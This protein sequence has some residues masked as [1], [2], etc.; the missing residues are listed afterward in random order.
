M[1]KR[2][3]YNLLHLLNKGGPA[4]IPSPASDSDASYWTET[5]SYGL[6][7]NALVAAYPNASAGAQVLSNAGTANQNI[8]KTNVL[9]GYGVVQNTASS[10]FA[11]TTEAPT[12]G[13]ICLLKKGISGTDTNDTFNFTAVATR[14]R[15]ASPGYDYY[16]NSAV[17]I[18]AVGGTTLLSWDTIIMRWTGQAVVIRINGVQKASF[19]AHGN[20]NTNNAFRLLPSLVGQFAALGRWTTD[21]G[22][23]RAATVESYLRT[24]YAHY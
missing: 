4:V 18:V 1:L 15:N 7:N 5:H 17:G 19:T 11:M 16:A 23:T 20:L 22:N 10:F 8:Y 9:N 3:Y 2:R 6:A 13:T 21:I 24:K 12:N 14:L